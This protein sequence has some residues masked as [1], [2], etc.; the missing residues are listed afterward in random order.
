M[1]RTQISLDDESRRALE[2]AAVL[3]GRSLSS[4]IREAIQKTY[5]SERSVDDDIA[6]MRQSFGAWQD[7]DI[8]GE[9]WVERRRSGSRW[10]DT[11]S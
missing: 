11:G 5:G 1:Q 4:L 3:T 8:S 7:H 6:K 2:S 10:H 9:A